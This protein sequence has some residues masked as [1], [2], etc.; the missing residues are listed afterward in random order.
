MGD[1]RGAWK[2]HDELMVA[3]SKIL[4]AWRQPEVLTSATGLEGQKGA[5]QSY[6]HSDPMAYHVL[7]CLVVTALK[8]REFANMS[9]DE[10]QREM[11][12]RKFEMQRILA[13]VEAHPITMPLI[14]P[15]G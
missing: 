8:L 12:R 2:E 7:K 4:Y 6:F 15:R 11:A 5:V 13:D 10:R 1:Y 3:F 14:T 9:E